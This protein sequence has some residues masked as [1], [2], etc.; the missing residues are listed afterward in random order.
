MDNIDDVMKYI[1][2]DEKPKKKIKKKK[3]KNKINMLDDLINKDD[4]HNKNEDCDDIDNGLSIISEADSVLD[5]FKSDIIAKTEYNTGNK[6]I[7]ILSS[8]FLGRFQE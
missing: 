7:P 1:E 8:D 4:S 3:N 6:V 5:C 2:D